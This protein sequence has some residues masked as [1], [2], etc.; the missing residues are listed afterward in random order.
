LQASLRRVLGAHVAQAGSLVAP[1]RL[2]FDFTHF[3]ALSG[4]EKE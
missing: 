3:S 2:R 1:E 4:A